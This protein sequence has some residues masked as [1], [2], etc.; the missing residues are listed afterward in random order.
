MKSARACFDWSS[1][2][3]RLSKWSQLFLLP[4]VLATVVFLVF[5]SYNQPET[6]RAGA[7]VAEVRCVEC[8]FSFLIFLEKVGGLVSES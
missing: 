3:H 7:F 8:C 2:V 6:L 4:F 1:P 5:F